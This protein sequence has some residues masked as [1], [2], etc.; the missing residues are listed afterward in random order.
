MEEHESADGWIGQLTIKTNE[1]NYKKCDR[2]LKEKFING[3]NDDS[4]DYH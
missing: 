1:C 3:I 2:Y 4:Q